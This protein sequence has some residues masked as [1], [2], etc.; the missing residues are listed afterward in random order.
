[1]KQESRAVARVLDSLSE[2]DRQKLEKDAEA[3]IP[4]GCARLAWKVT[5][6]A[7][8]GELVKERFLVSGCPK[9]S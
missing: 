4:A 2:S 9:V 6:L 7:M 1:M 5:R 3:R 8:L